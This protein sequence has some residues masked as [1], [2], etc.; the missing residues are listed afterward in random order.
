M[1]W[2][3]NRCGA[4]FLPRLKLSRKCKTAQARPQQ[5]AVGNACVL[6]GTIVL[7]LLLLLHAANVAVSVRSYVVIYASDP[8]RTSSAWPWG[9]LVGPFGV[10]KT[11]FWK[12]YF[13]FVNKPHAAAFPFPGYRESDGTNGRKRKR[14]TETGKGHSKSEWKQGVHGPGVFKLDFYLC[15]IFY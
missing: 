9:I 13:H 10:K 1:W 5:F 2:L 12:I 11:Y 3:Y 4:A 6:S 8:D 14:N 15:N 7:L